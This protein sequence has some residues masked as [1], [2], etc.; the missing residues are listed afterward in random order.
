MSNFII[1]PGG[2]SA[3]PFAK[4]AGDGTDLGAAGK[5]WRTRPR[6]GT[7]VFGIDAYKGPAQAGKNV[8]RHDFDQCVI[9]NI[10][11]LYIATSPANVVAA[12]LADV[13]AIMNASNGCVLNL[14]DYASAFNR[15]ECTLCEPV[16]Y[17]GG[18]VVKRTGFGSPN[19]YRMKVMMSFIQM[20]Q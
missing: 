20:E 16:P 12:W 10:S 3:I 5:L 1:T 17:S 2:G 15:C 7:P 9:D 4:L 13:T 19:T 18:A 6:A 8:R 11:V 14:P